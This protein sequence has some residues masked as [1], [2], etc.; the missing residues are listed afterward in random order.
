MYL[1]KI[2]PSYLEGFLPYIPENLLGSLTDQRYTYLGCVSG[3]LACGA[4]V[5][6]SDA[7]GK[8]AVIRSI[9]VD[10]KVR[11]R[12]YGT[13]LMKGLAK[14]AAQ[15]GLSALRIFYALD[16]SEQLALESFLKSCGFGGFLNVSTTFKCK[17][18]DLRRSAFI[19]KYLPFSRRFSGLVPFRDLPRDQLD[20]MLA[21]HEREIPEFL[22]IDAVAFDPDI[23][24][25]AV[26]SGGIKGYILAGE[27]GGT[28]EISSAIVFGSPSIVSGTFPAL[29]S[30]C[31]GAILSRCDDDKWVSVDS[32]NNTVTSMARNAV[33]GIPHRIIQGK[34][35]FLQLT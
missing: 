17:L 31:L 35:A 2:S 19:K 13:A 9:L 6:E 14:T 27:R 30:A 29:V 12:G 34:E 24:F 10:E 28:V 23:S 5:S 1:L 32:V 18:G 16:F 22:S 3:G 21:A 26:G 8:E 11:R 7:S 20:A 15:A 25:A 33:A 4:A